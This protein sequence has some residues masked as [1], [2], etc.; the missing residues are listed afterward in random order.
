MSEQRASTVKMVV[1]AVIGVALFSAVAYYVMVPFKAEAK[2]CQIED[3]VLGSFQTPIEALAAP[4]I[5]YFDGAGAERR[6]TD[7]R[8]RGIVLNFW[9]TWCAPCVREMPQ[10]DRLKELVAANGVDVLAISEDRQGA[11]VVKKFYATNKLHGL[12][13][14]VDKGGK[15][16]RS[17]KGRGLP[18][19]VLFNKMGQE[20]G[21]VTGIAEWDSP[22]AVAFIRR[23]LGN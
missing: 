3:G 8:G 17:L 5:A 21:R 4:D 1:L 22:E 6:L 7:L 10:L 20:V 11:L 15:L 12:D 13:I 9:A 23:C 16:I 18:T 14:L 19:T 2:A